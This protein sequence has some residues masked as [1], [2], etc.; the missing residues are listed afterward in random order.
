MTRISVALLVL[1]V[2]TP[3][4]A[5]QPAVPQ[6]AR[7]GPHAIEVQVNDRW[8]NARQQPR[9]TPF[10]A[11]Q[12][13]LFVDSV[14]EGNA[15]TRTL[16]LSLD[17]R[18]A[19]QRATIVTRPD[20]RLVGVSTFRQWRPANGAFPA[21]DTARLARMALFDDAGRL[22]IPATKVWDVAPSFHPARLR[23]GEQWL[24]SI[25]L[26]AD[27]Y[28][29]R[30]VLTGVRFSTLGGDTTID[31]RHL[32]IVNDS[33]AVRYDERAMVRER[34]LDTLVAIERS[35]SGTV[36]G[37]MLYDTELGL[38]RARSDTTVLTGRAVLLY[39]DGRR[40][41]TPAR[42]ERRRQWHLYDPS[43]YNTRQRAI[44]SER[45]RT[46][47]G[48]VVISPTNDVDRRLSHND[49][50]ARDS[51]VSVWEQSLEP[52]AWTGIYGRLTMWGGRDTAFLRRLEDLRIAAGD[53]AFLFQT[54]ARRP[55]GSWHRNAVGVDS[56]TM[57]KLIAL[58]AT[59][60]LLFA[61]AV[62]RDP[63]YEDLVQALI[64]A[65]PATTRDTT[66]WPCTPGAC[67]LLAEQWSLA[68]EP[69]LKMVGL[70]AHFVLDPRR[71]TDSVLAYVPS[72]SFL[73]AALLLARG[74]GATWPAASKA[75]MPAPGADWRAWI[76]WMNGQDP[77]YAKRVASLPAAA[78]LPQSSVRF[79]GTHATAIRFT[80]ARTGRNIIDE[81]KRQL[82][83]ATW[84][85]AQLVYEYMLNGLGEHRPTPE[86][87][88]AHLRSGSAARIA[89]ATREVESLFKGTPP[90]ADSATALLLIDRLIG[91]NVGAERPWRVLRPPGDT[92]SSRMS[93]LPPREAPGE[94]TLFLADSM[95]AALRAKWTGRVPIITSAEWAN[96]SE[97]TGGTLFTLTSVARV[98]PFA[99]LGIE[100]AG[101]LDR[102]A[103]QAPW[104]YYGGTTYYLM[105]LDGEWVLVT[106][107]SWI[108]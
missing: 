24:D 53:T 78:R 89:L 52:N 90:R 76:E 2:A 23:R 58:M 51:L 92:T 99:R 33:A 21:V 68:T 6:A 13:W 22:A 35:A 82:A 31:G 1:S 74:V 80:Q 88:A 46:M 45:E 54:L 4:T 50:S 105:E 62:D 9:F 37:R 93:I 87:I 34:T 83:A 100:S 10:R 84:D 38:F 66:Q 8:L 59:P 70:V 94:R 86:T 71:W 108:T 96:R 49:V 7:I 107:M 91:M 48:G 27:E 19:A 79:D 40:F 73:G 36:R 77:E 47:P 28:G 72:R 56:A 63:F 67:R 69:R 16:F 25:A 26:S 64:M 55:F 3:A 95:P 81:L 65:P 42:Y 14:H 102:R 60:D 85:S 103:D 61:F 15:D 44:E 12:R 5:Q 32:W 43:E 57:V 39:P 11:S 104:L 41:E 29:S 106:A 18:N 75:S 17:R 30:Q 101:R 20:G 97:R 98:G